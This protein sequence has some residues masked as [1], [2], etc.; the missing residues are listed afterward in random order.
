MKLFLLKDLYGDCVDAVIVAKNDNI[1]AE[2]IQNSIDETK[3]KYGGDWQWDNI[4]NGLPKDCEIY[5][6]WGDLETVTY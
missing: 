3:E 1:T 2:E 4:V 5:D 6:K